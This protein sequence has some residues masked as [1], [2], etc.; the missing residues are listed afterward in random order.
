MFDTSPTWELLK[1][2]GTIGGLVAP[3]FLIYDRVFRRR[4]C[5]FLQPKDFGLRLVLRNTSDETLIIDEI[6]VSPL[7]VDVAMGNDLLSHI[8]AVW[9]PKMTTG[10][11]QRTFCVLAPQASRELGL[12]TSTAFEA[13]P[14]ATP[15]RIRCEWRATS[16]PWPFKRHVWVR[17]SVDDIRQLKKVAQANR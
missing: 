8:Q 12:V 11:I 5:A 15:V 3:I 4:P 7:G 6:A 9:Y 16:R 1:V 10:D 13:L 2:L 14:P 17:A